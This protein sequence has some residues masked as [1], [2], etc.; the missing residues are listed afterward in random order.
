MTSAVL[1]IPAL[2]LEAANQLGKTMGWGDGNYTVPLTM[3][4]KT[5]SHYG[6]RADVQQGFMD[7]MAN[8]PKEAAP[9][10]AVLVSDFRETSDGFGHWSE[11]LASQKLAVLSA[12]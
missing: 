5:V 3:D 9:I 2:Y 7:L 1:I 8:P 6:C 12:D 10:L 11:V 4:G